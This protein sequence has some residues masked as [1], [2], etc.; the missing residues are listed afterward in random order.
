MS[1]FHQLSD[2]N[3]CRPPKSSVNA[4]APA[5]AS[6][7]RGVDS[8]GALGFTESEGAEG[9]PPQPAV[10]SNS[11]HMKRRMARR[12]RQETDQLVRAGGRNLFHP[13]MFTHSDG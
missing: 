11:E 6:G 5:A 4:T 10:T 3:S 7:T 12:P 1:W 2:G 8:V 13:V 9:V